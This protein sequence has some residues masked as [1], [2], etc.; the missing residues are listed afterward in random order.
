MSKPLTIQRMLNFLSPLIIA[1]AALAWGFNA[2]AQ[3]PA[4]TYPIKPIK[5]IAPVAAGG[6]LDNIARTLAE[7]MSK[8]LG[9]TIVVDNM[10]GGGGSQRLRQI[11][12]P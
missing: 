11:A 6:G 8:S 4:T 7:R 1:S 10:G 2:Q 3:A 12:T 5:L 9:Q